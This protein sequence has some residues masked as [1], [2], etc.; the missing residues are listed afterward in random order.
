MGVGVNAPIAVSASSICSNCTIP[1]PLLRV[2][3]YIIS[4]CCSCPVVSNN[5]TRSSFA[6]DQGSCGN[7][8]ADTHKKIQQTCGERHTFV[9]K[10][11]CTGT[12]SPF[13]PPPN[14]LPELAPSGPV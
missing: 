3:S 10:I 4:A 13:G 7:S 8:S 5:S 12:T 6:V 1:I 11:C 14:P 2:P 9:T